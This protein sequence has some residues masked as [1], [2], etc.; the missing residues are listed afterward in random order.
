MAM[1]SDPLR[2]ARNLYLVGFGESLAHG[3]LYASVLEQNHL[4]RF[5]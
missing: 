3:E 2:F 4:T 1:A 5:D